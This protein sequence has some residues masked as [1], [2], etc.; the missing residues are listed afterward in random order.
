MTLDVRSKGVSLREILVGPPKIT[1]Q[2]NAVCR[3]LEV[4]V[5]NTG[6]L[7]VQL[8]N[9]IEVWYD[10]KRWFYGMVFKRGADSKGN[11]KY[12]AYDPLFYFKKHE[13]D[14]YVKNQTAT[15]Y[16][17]KLAGKVGVKVASLA[18]TGVVFKALWYPGKPADAVAI[19]LLA[20]T[21]QSNGKKYWLRFNPYTDDFGLKLFERKPPKE[22]WAFQ[23]GVNLIDTKYDESVEEMYN[24][25]KLVNRETGK[26]VQKTNDTHKVS[27]G[28]MQK[29]KEVDKDSK[30]TME[31]QAQALLNSLSKVK[32]ETTLKGINPDRKMPQLFVGDYVYVQ[33]TFTGMYG[34]YHIADI[35]HTFISDNLV[36]ITAGVERTPD[37]PAIQ[38]EDAG[39]KPDYL[40]TKAELEAEKKAASKKVK[41]PAAKKPTTKK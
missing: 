34:A 18:N 32:I 26:T 30:Q 38:Y 39:T 6:K 41:K 22:V 25:V 37:M 20:R 40:K 7:P 36:E 5:R 27:F 14:F 9:A 29:F 16:I 35:T 15:Q 2:K 24:G 31:K 17:T 4:T 19:D 21:G 23:A 28:Y 11:V 1:D 3:T 8:G 13:D 12:V 10:E 33:E